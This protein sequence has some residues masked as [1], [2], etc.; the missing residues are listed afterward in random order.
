MFITLSKEKLSWNSVI[1]IDFHCH[2]RYLKARTL[3]HFI[4]LEI[5]V[6]DFWASDTLQQY[7]N[8]FR[9]S[10]NSFWFQPYR[11]HMSSHKV[12]A[13]VANGLFSVMR[14]IPLL[15]GRWTTTFHS[16]FG[17]GTTPSSP[18][19]NETRLPFLFGSWRTSYTPLYTSTVSFNC[20]ATLRAAFSTRNQL[21]P[22]TTCTKHK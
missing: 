5:R 9:K 8:P 3:L 20:V 14:T 17:T 4:D 2:Y 10:W 6:I 16:H 19:L 11:E 12:S 1:D 13:L 18:K 15:L 21:P 7:V 22:F